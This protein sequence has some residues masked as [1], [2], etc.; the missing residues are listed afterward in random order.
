M[1]FGHRNNELVLTTSVELRGTPPTTTRA[2]VNAFELDIEKPRINQ[3][4]E[5]ELGHMDRDVDAGGSLLTAGGRRAPYDVPVQVSAHRL[6]ERG[7]ALD[8]LVIAE[9]ASHF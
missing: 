9:R 8:L 1:A 3:L 2:F 4:V 7:D 6:G 5:V